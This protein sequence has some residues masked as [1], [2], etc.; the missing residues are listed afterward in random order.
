MV[1]VWEVRGVIGKQPVR[2]LYCFVSMRACQRSEAA[3]TGAGAAPV[4]SSY[5]R[6]LALMSGPSPLVWRSC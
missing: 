2:T 4:V 5:E 1:R 6:V 3:V